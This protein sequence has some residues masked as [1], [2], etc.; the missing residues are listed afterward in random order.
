MSIVRG[1]VMRR[2]SMSSALPCCEMIVEH[3][4]EQRV[5]ARD[6]VEVA[7]EMEIDV[8]HRHDLRIAAA[9]RAAFHAEHRTEARLANAEHSV[10]A[11]PAQRLRETDERRALPFAGRRGI[12]RRDDDEPP[13]GRSLRD[14]E[15]GIFALYFP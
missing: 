12:R 5:R 3:R 15:I 10:S 13:A 8:V 14:L 9:R 4:R 1:Q 11:K 7:G 6:R 2:G